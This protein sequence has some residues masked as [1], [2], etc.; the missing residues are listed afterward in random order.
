MNKE[1]EF[2]IRLVVME[3]WIEY[4]WPVLDHALK[5]SE[6]YYVVWKFGNNFSNKSSSDVVCC[7]KCE[8]SRRMLGRVTNRGGMAKLIGRRR[9]SLGR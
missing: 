8:G 5:P 2:L 9:L 7:G 3:S 1:I 4:A 6:T